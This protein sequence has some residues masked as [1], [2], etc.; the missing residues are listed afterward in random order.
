MFSQ[1]R[2]KLFSA[3]QEGRFSHS[4]GL[5]LISLGWLSAARIRN[6]LYD[7]GFLPARRLPSLVISVGNIVAGGSGKTPLVHLL[8]QSL[9]PLGPIAI[10]S[11][12]YQSKRSSLPLGDELTMLSR[13]LPLIL[14]Y[15]GKDRVASGEKAIQGGARILLL[16]DG[17]QYRRLRRDFDFV[18][19]DAANPFGYGAFLP[20]GLLRD[21]PSRLRQADAVFV[22]GSMSRTLETA[23]R[24]WSE[25]P[26]IG[27]RQRFEKILDLEGQPQEIGQVRRAGAF[28]GI[29][30]PHRFM[31]SLKEARFEIVDHWILA[32]HGKPDPV[33]LERFAERCREKGA[34]CLVCTQKDAV[35]LSFDRRA[36][37]IYYLEMQLEIISQMA[38]WQ[39][40]IEKI[41]LKMNN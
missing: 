22:N 31:Q 41:S 27:V 11:R 8:A 15:A 7:R 28:C 36:L 6:W 12:G 39:N 3:A 40:L 26:L 24:R 30:Q 17:F 14:P 16:D 19:V 34:T 21:S 13:R 10:L 32:D 35:K 1:L 38:E 20:C 2:D 25:A 9:Q 33:R 29:G 4:L 23:L 18:I 5:R 37:P